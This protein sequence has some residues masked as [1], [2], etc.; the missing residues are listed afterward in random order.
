MNVTKVPGNELKNRMDRFI[1]Q[2]DKT[3]AGWE[4][5]VITGSMSMY[6]LTGTICDGLL[7]IRR[8][9]DAVLWARRGYDR[10]VLESE[11]GEIRSMAGFRDVAGYAGKLPDTLYLDMAAATLEWHG[12]FNKYMSF[13]KILPVD[14]VMLT[15]RSVK[16]RYEIDIMSR[17]GGIIHRLLTEELPKV[18]YAGIS[19]AELGAAMYPILIKNGYHGISR[20]SMKNTDVVLGHIG[21]GESPLYPSVFNGASGIVGLCPA[22]PVLGSRD[23]KLK[24]GDLIYVDIGFGIDGYNVDKTVVFSYRKGQPDYVNDIHEHCLEI[25]R[26]AVSMMRAGTKPS[27]IYKAAIESVKPEIAG[28]FM[29]TEGRTVQ[30]LGH[31]VGLYID[32]FPVIAKGFDESLECGM[33]IAIEPKAG[34]KGAGM[35]GSENTYLVTESGAVCLTGNALEIVTVD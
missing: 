20:F 7:M 34:I 2:M 11:F 6:W 10:A 13:E 25:E 21:F 5:C 17:A 33:T 35:V 16:S 27:D 18:L 26:Q 31:G 22:V 32:E 29:G 15:A 24:E 1:M 14:K 4:I 9:K 28:F 23:V 12:I 3:Y 19:E 8:G 30:F